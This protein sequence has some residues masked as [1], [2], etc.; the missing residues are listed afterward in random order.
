MTDFSI[1]LTSI[2]NHNYQ[3]F[4]KNNSSETDF[5]R[6]IV[7][8]TEI[9]RGERIGR[10]LDNWIISPLKKSDEHVF[11]QQ[12][13]KRVM[14]SRRLWVV[15]E[16]VKRSKPSNK[17]IGSFLALSPPQSKWRQPIGSRTYMEVQA[18]T[19]ERTPR[20]QIEELIHLRE[21]PYMGSSI[22]LRGASAI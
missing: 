17:T 2:G 3:M 20:G 10:V 12:A 19:K 9:V 7:G 8:Y 6:I 14:R 21:Y 5:I 1:Y 22:L 15:F 11:I 18:I 16:T 13:N 4:A